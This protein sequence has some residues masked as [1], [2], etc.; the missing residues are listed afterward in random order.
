MT[1]SLRHNVW[2]QVLASNTFS[3]VEHQQQIDAHHE[4]SAT[5]W[6]DIYALEGID[7]VI[8]QQRRDLVLSLVDKLALTPGSQFLEVGCGAGVTAV[9]LAKRGNVVHALDTVSSMLDLTREAALQAGVA[10]RVKTSLGDAHALPFADN[11]FRLVLSMGVTTCLHSLDQTMREMARVLEPGGYLIINA[12]NRWRLNHLLDPPLFPALAPLRWK[13]RDAFG[14][15]A[16]RPR[17][18]M[19]SIREFDTIVQAAGL[20]KLQGMTLG[21]GPF[22]L[23]NQKVLPETASVKLHN[24]LQ[25]LADRNFPVLRS[26]GV[27]YIVLAKKAAH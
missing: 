10:E 3:S 11:A 13:L 23:F 6:R 27:Q 15:A 18:R 20:K 4:A 2:V 17:L 19:Y 14:P 25:K 21:F 26:T 1:L 22:S 9:D 12:E 7:A 24:R 8:C 5:Y 16:K